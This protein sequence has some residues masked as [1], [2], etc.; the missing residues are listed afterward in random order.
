[1]SFCL[2]YSAITKIFLEWLL[3]KIIIIILIWFPFLGEQPKQSVHC[4]FL[5]ER[6]IKGNIYSSTHSHTHIYIVVINVL[7]KRKEKET[8][9]FSAVFCY[10]WFPAIYLLTCE[11]FV[12]TGVLYDPEWKNKT[13]LCLPQLA[14]Q[15][16]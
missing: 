12:C 7:K 16:L 15:M 13:G 4:T 5:N 8:K 14:G 2:Q 10:T 9:Y 3:S 1:M 6:H 11:H